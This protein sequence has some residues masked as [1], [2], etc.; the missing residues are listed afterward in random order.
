MIHWGEQW[1]F[2]AQLLTL[3]FPIYY[4]CLKGKKVFL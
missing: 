4:P 3:F 1:T 2:F